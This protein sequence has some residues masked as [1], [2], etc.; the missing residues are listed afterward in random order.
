[1]GQNTTV[2]GRLEWGEAPLSTSCQQATNKL[3]PRWQEA[4]GR[5]VFN[6][7]PPPSRGGEREPAVAHGATTKC[8]WY[9]PPFWR[10][11]WHPARS[12]RASCLAKCSRAAPDIPPQTPRPRSPRRPLGISCCRSAVALAEGQP[13]LRAGL[14]R[15]PAARKRENIAHHWRWANDVRCVTKTESRRPVHV[16]G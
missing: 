4:W 6:S 11:G 7:S 3:P 15:P 1:M 13:R 9:N 14:K 8:K 2:G 5:K 10:R 16:P 12:K